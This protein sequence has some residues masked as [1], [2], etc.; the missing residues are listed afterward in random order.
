MQ[1]KAK[2]SARQAPTAGSQLPLEST[3]SLCMEGSLLA[4]LGAATLI[5]VD[6]Y[7]GDVLC[8]SMRLS[9]WLNLAVNLWALSS[10]LVG[11]MT[12]RCMSEVHHHSLQFKNTKGPD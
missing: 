5:P 3:G 11:S 6:D 1:V 8:F 4:D 9:R 12:S 7:A 10:E 2:F